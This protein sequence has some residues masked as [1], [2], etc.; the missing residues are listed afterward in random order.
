MFV[1]G[2][3]LERMRGL[4]GREALR[5]REGMLLQSCRLI[6]TYGMRYPIDVVYLSRGG[7]VIKVTEALVPR[8]MSGALRADSVLEMAAGE[9]RRCGIHAGLQLPIM[10]RQSACTE[11][12]MNAPRLLAR[13]RGQSMTEFLVVFPALVLLVFGIIQFALL[14]QTR[15][16]LNHATMLAA[17]LGALNNGSDAAMRLALGNGLAP[18]FA[19]DPTMGGYIYAVKEA[20]KRTIKGANMVDLTVLNPT[21]AAMNDFGRTKLNGTG[22]RELPNDTLS[23]RSVTPGTNSKISVQDANILHVRVE[24]C[25]HDRA[26]C[27]PRHLRDRECLPAFRSRARKWRHGQSLRLERDRVQTL[28]VVHESAAQGWPAHQDSERSIC[29]YAISVL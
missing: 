5:Q 10:R 6:H 13:A 3:M 7:K 14:Y 15:L 25:A 24:F 21:K 29:S 16:T 22:G 27:R 28:A 8:R 2:S 9:A 20:N 23:Y 17:P 1:A 4:L 12:G 19:L 26:D 18:L 11:R